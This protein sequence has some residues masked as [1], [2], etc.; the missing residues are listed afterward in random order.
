MKDRN[1]VALIQLYGKMQPPNAEPLSVA[2]LA[3]ALSAEI[4][5][6]SIELF[7]LSYLDGEKGLGLL[8]NELTDCRP[9]L[10]GVSIPQSTYELSLKLLDSLFRQFPS[11]CIVIGHALPSYCPEAFLSL[12]PKL[13]IIR[14]WG[15]ESI[16]HLANIV[17][18]GENN[19]DIIPNLVFLHDGITAST[20]VKWPDKIY[21]PLRNY[22]QNYYARIEASRGCSHNVCTFCTR[23]M[24]SHNLEIPWIRRNY[25]QIISDLLELRSKGINRVTFTDEDFVGNDLEGALKIARKILEMGNF[26]FSLSVR[27]DNI[28][29][30][31][32]SFLENEKS[33]KLFEALRDGGLELVFVG[34]ESFSKAQLK[35]YVKGINPDDNLNALAVLRKLGINYEIGLVIFDPLTSMAE[36]QENLD[37]LDRTGIWSKVGN[38]T[39]LLR[40]QAGSSYVKILAS[41]GL[42]GKFNINT[43]SYDAKFLD[44]KIAILAK[45]YRGWEEEIDIIHLHCRNIERTSTSQTVFAKSLFDMRSLFFRALKEAFKKLQSEAS[46]VTSQDIILSEYYRERDEIIHS[47]HYHLSRMKN[48]NIMEKDLLYHCKNYL[49]SSNQYRL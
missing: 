25:E 42:L 20:T 41:A 8:L 5:G 3:G 44:S 30:P 34:A 36:M 9:F 11:S 14:G 18:R 15:E 26:Q 16:I 46:L 22:A 24:G 47:L 1:T 31:Q 38:L 37:I 7:T 28:Y 40:P 48:L 43:L 19:L 12:Y 39:T 21:A 45:V 10:I 23:P 33:K 29:S 13:I 27:A 32:K 2:V 35:R 6:L 17:L 49:S 4:S